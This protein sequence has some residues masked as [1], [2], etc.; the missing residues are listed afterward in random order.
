M[1]RLLLVLTLCFYSFFAN[2]Q[3]TER[4]QQHIGNNSNK[5]V[6]VCI[7]FNSA[8]S[9]DQI[10]FEIE[11][12]SLSVEE[13]QRYLLKS[14]LKEQKAQN[15]VLNYL[16]NASVHYESFFAV[17]AIVAKVLP[18]QLEEIS[19]LSNIN[20]ID[21]SVGVVQFDKP[22]LS[23]Q[24]NAQKTTGVTAEPGLLAIN[25]PEMWKLGYTGRGRKVYVY[26]TGV[27]AE[28]PAFESRFMGK[29]VPLDQA[30]YGHFADKPN[31][32][33]G[34]HGTHVLGTVGGLDTL[35]KDT[36]GAA[37]GSY[38]MACDLINGGTAAG[39]PDQAYLIA[40]F[41][42]ALN[43]DG[44]T[45]TTDD[46]PDVINNSWRWLDNTDTTECFGFIPQLMSTIEAAGIANVFSGGNTGPNNNG[47][48]SPQRI[49]TTDIN[50]FTVGSVNGNLPFPHPISSFSTRG[51][52]QCPG[53]GSL[54]LFPEVVAPGQN[55]RSAWGVDGY[56]TISGTSMAS[57][58]VSGALLLL[59]EAFPN[60]TGAQLLQALY[61]TA[62][63]MGV[64]GEDNVYGRG[65]I[66]VYAAY[67]HLALTHSPTDPMN[68]AWDIALTMNEDV[69]EYTCDSLYPF[70]AVVTNLGD[71]G[72]SSIIVEL[73]WN[74]FIMNGFPW[75]VQ[76]PSLMTKG[77][78]FSLDNVLIDFPLFAGKYD[79]T[80]KVRTGKPE[81]DFVN[82]QRHISFRKQEIKS[83]PFTED[84]ESG[85][86]PEKWRIENP[87][88]NITWDSSAVDGWIGNLNSMY[89]NSADYTPLQNQKD[90]LI[91]TEISL[92][93]NINLNLAFD[94][95]YQSI[96]ASGLRQ[97]SL[98]VWIS[99]DCGNN[100]TKIWEK[101]G[102]DLQT[103]A[104]NGF[105]FEPSG[106]GEWRRE[107]IDLTPYRSSTLQIKFQSVNRKGNNMY[108]DNI[109]VFKGVVDP[110]SV[111]ESEGFEYAVFPNPADSKV[112]I[113]TMLKNG[114][115]LR[116][117]SIDGREILFHK[118]EESTTSLSVEDLEAGV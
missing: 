102:T 65:L 69:A 13:R 26:D 42:W 78:T 9:I 113:E 5:V 98:Q 14:L 36:I 117:I 8:K 40:A 109:S 108:L 95:A 104:T 39:L 62:I 85:L 86:K 82:N 57:P 96:G 19:A 114:F 15:E 58:H 50:T 97:D 92:P 87:D 111:T 94:V 20:F 30:W 115:T 53:S 54:S 43:P 105:N 75:P 116:I 68:V 3:Y 103:T 93:D 89:L 33:L 31:G 90:G 71:S 51:P 32:H 47:V 79:L 74:G 88:F 91:T 4:L 60:L 25:A 2:A 83:L 56:N 67:Q 35:T 70:N 23:N 1:K 118:S 16:D 63:D 28:H 7:Y 38:W 12:L 66:D 22:I 110:L 34:S 49:N 112:N 48:R 84:F 100:F 61:T 21:L 80:L 77:G 10:A 44:D 45:T 29:H 64:Q 101:A 17:N 55:V 6:P 106:K 81:V 99:A 59:K 37:F 46:I 41:E 73:Y 107:Y 52:T 27:W 18:E 11:A 24:T 72:I 76:T